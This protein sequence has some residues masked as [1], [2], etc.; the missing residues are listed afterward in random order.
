MKGER[1][2]RREKMREMRRETNESR[3]TRRYYVLWSGAVST[4]NEYTGRNERIF[5][6]R[7]EGEI[8]GRKQEIERRK[9][10]NCF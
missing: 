3:S 1:K 9:R 10:V 5:K 4:E 2:G 6:Q 7:R 8:F